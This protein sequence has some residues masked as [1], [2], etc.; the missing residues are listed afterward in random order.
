LDYEFVW[1]VEPTLEFDWFGY[2]YLHDV[3]LGHGAF[4]VDERTGLSTGE[5][6]H[7]HGGNDRYEWIY[8]PELDMMGIAGSLYHGTPMRLYPRSEFAERFPDYAECM[9]TVYS[10]DSSMN[11]ATEWGDDLPP[12]AYSRAAVAVGSEF[13]TD[14]IYNDRANDF[15][16]RHGRSVADKIE[17]IDENGFHGIINRFGSALMPFVFDG[18]QLIDDNTAFAQIDGL[19]GIVIIEPEVPADDSPPS[20]VRDELVVN[21]DLSSMLSDSFRQG[22]S[23]INVPGDANSSVESITFYGRKNLNYFAFCEGYIEDGMIYLDE[24][25]FDVSY[26]SLSDYYIEYKPSVLADDR[27]RVVVVREVGADGFDLKCY[28]L[29]FDSHGMAYFNETEDVVLV[30]F[31]LGATQ[32]ANTQIPL[33]GGAVLVLADG[34]YDFTTSL[35]VVHSDGDSEF[36]FDN[37][38]P[39]FSVSP[40][41]TKIAF[42]LPEYRADHGELRIFDVIS[43]ETTVIDTGDDIGKGILW[44]DDDYLLFLAGFAA[45]SVS[46]GGALNY[47]RVSDGATRVIINYREIAKIEDAGDYLDYT[48]CVIF[49]HAMS[50]LRYGERVSRAE[51]YNLIASGTTMSLS[52]PLIEGRD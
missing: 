40:D 45:G 42:M 17:A 34:E 6:H 47:Y 39:R 49:N 33:A 3:F 23:P 8:D 7:A 21:V 29:R 25:V 31:P 9:K 10:V 35:T 13:V 51:I 11:D 1:L 41:G 26:F 36:L 20:G 27:V 18:I 19:W 44:L 2:C 22:K 30:P 28:I 5:V 32:M 15:W 38:M 4:T 12:E 24:L 48:I 43:R 37:W 52:V 14:F 46:Q 50:Y 16:I